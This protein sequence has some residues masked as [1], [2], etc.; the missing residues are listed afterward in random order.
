M[1]IKGCQYISALTENLISIDPL[2]NTGY[3][4]DLGKSSWKIMKGVMVVT[5]GTKSRTLYTTTRYMN[6]VAVTES[7]SN[8]IL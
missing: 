5:R 7:A 3:V 2:D 6:M 8:S 1:N 4:I